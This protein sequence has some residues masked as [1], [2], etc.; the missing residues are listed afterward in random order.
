MARAGLAAR[1]GRVPMQMR[2][3]TGDTGE[4]YV[5]AQGWLEA[6]LAFCPL[7]PRGGCGFARHGTY[8]RVSPPGSI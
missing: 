7:H 5:T 2:L 1:A 3:V 6:S 4:G 8:A